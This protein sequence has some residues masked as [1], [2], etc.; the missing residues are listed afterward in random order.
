M[1]IMQII[2]KMPNIMEFFLFNLPLTLKYK[3]NPMIMDNKT[4]MIIFK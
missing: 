4:M 2:D 3:N 1:I